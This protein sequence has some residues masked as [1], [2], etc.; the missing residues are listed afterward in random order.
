MDEINEEDTVEITAGLGLQAHPTPGATRGVTP[1][2]VNNAITST[3][4]SPSVS[5]YSTTT[6][7]QAN[8]VPSF[9]AST[10]L[11]SSSVVTEEEAAFM[12]LANNNRSILRNSPNKRLRI[13]NRDIARLFPFIETYISS[14]T[15]GATVTYSGF[16]VK[17]LWLYH[18]FL[19]KKEIVQGFS[20]PFYAG[21]HGSAIMK[22][23]FHGK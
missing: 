18:L 21:F 14:V 6:L 17:D 4:T 23:F 1:S 9:S 3:L 13:E 2:L 20:T 19:Q 11:T 16:A 22:S 15:G 10:V 12:A 8:V 7:A 5:S